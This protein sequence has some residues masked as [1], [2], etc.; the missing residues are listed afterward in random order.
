MSRNKLKTVRMIELS[1]I[2]KKNT[3]GHKTEW[4][5]QVAGMCNSFMSGVRYQSTGEIKI[6][7]VLLRY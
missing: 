7:Q 6:I 2:I 1:D 4:T 3:K 5:E